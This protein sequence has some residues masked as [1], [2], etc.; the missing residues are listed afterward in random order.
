MDND[1]E[2]TN[3]RKDAERFPSLLVGVPERMTQDKMQGPGR[4][5]I[6]GR[7]YLVERPTIQDEDEYVWIGADA[8]DAV[9]D[10]PFWIL[11]RFAP[12]EMQGIRGGTMDWSRPY[13]VEAVR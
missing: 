11:W 9:T 8:T 3:A 7:T 2:E 1:R 12:S 5:E 10:E 6:G 4:L 13:N